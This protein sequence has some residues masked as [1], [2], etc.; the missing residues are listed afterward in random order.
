MVLEALRKWAGLASLFI[1]SGFIFFEFDR[2]G[3]T[4]FLIG[5]VYILYNFMKDITDTPRRFGYV[6][7]A[8]LAAS[9]VVFYFYIFFNVWIIF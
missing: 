6:A 9:Y 1:G 5:A 2:I 7:P 4:V 8:F 3:L